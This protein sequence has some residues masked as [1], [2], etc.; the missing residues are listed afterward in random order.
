MPVFDIAI[1]FSGEDRAVAKRIASSLVRNGLNVFYDEYERANLWGKDLYVHLT[2]IYRDDAKYC[3]MLISEHYAKKQWTNHE[4]RAAQARAFSE[5]CEYILPLRLDD[6]PLD[7][8][9]DTIG[10]LDLRKTTIEE[11]VETV[12]EKIFVYNKENG[13]TYELVKVE[14]VLAKQRIGPKGGRPIKD[15]DMTTT[16]PACGTAQRLSDATLSLDRAETVYTCRNGCQAIVIIGRPGVVAWP[17]RGYRLGDHVVRNIQDILVKTEDM[18][19]ILVLSAQKAALMKSR[20][21]S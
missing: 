7:G 4:R 8:V 6:T 15:A 14:D 5:N 10:Y 19:A 17:G 3:L 2:K 21:Q 16:C 18:A 20:P 13:I 12:V 11:I 9:L 1:S